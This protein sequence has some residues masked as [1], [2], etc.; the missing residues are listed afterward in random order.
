[1]ISGSPPLPSC[2]K[3]ICQ[4]KSPVCI[5]IFNTLV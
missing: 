2:L 4:S 3:R 5:I 1:L